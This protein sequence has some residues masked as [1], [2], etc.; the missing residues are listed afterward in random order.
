[1]ETYHKIQ[2][3]FNRD[4]Q[5]K[6]L[7]IGD[8]RDKTIEYLKDNLWEFTEKVDG[9]NIRVCWD[10]YKVKFAGRT[11]KA[12]IPS[13]LLERL[14]TILVAKLTSKYLSKSLEKRKLFS[15]ARDMVAK[16]KRVIYTETTKTSFCLTLK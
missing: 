4:E 2:T 1:M 16:Y 9:T 6:K 3:L 5:T 10:G 12:N 13:R 11:D 15:S 8:Y 14:T 7:I